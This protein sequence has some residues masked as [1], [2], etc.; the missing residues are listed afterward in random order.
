MHEL[1][2]WRKVLLQVFAVFSHRF[3]TCCETTEVAVRLRP[4]QMRELLISRDLRGLA[5]RRGP[6]LLRVSPLLFKTCCDAA[7]PTKMALKKWSEFA[8]AR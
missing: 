5:S 2:L 4:S 3:L 7:G 8:S 1:R 6:G